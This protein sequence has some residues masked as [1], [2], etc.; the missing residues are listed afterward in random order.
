M[1]WIEVGF[2]YA[3]NFLLILR[4]GAVFVDHAGTVVKPSV[5]YPAS[6]R[7]FLVFEVSFSIVVYSPRDLST[8][9]LLFRY[10][11]LATAF[12]GFFFCSLGW[13]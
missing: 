2:F 4:V 9:S 1:T 12:G 3:F 10:L 8:F 13:S 7:F 11:S 6:L 5:A